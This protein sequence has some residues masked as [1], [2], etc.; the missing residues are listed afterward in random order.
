[1]TETER[2]YARLLEI[3]SFVTAT[4]GRY[5]AYLL[6]LLRFITAFTSLMV[7][8]SALPYMNRLKSVPLV[9]I[10]S[11]VCSLL[12]MAFTLLVAGAF[13]VLHL[14]ELSM[15]AAIVTFALLIVMY[16]L[17]FRFTPKDAGFVLLTPFCFFLRLPHVLPLLGGLLGSV[18]S[19]LALACGIV[20]YYFLGYI[21]TNAAFLSSQT[22]DDLLTSIKYCLDGLTGNKSMLVLIAAFALT[23][24]IVYALRRL[25]VDYAWPIAI[26]A[27]AIV[28]VV[29]L[30]IGTLFYDTDLNVPGLLLSSVFSVLI[31][32]VVQFFA[33]NMDYRRTENVQ[34][35]DDEYYYYVKAIPKASVPLRNPQVKRIH[36]P[37]E[38]TYEK[39]ERVPAYRSAGS[40]QA[41]SKQASPAS[42][43]RQ[44]SSAVRQ[45][46]PS[47]RQA[48]VPS[49]QTG[50]PARHVPAPT[51]PA[52]SASVPSSRA[53]SAS[54]TSVPPKPNLNARQGTG[55][56]NAADGNVRGAINGLRDL[57]RRDE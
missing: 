48:S 14:Y 51:K 42:P 19:F 31:A 49:R 52:A 2:L 35:E 10:V 21:R 17:Y 13:I 5:E 29:V 6:P 9:L 43:S 4:V 50:T 28:N 1:M 24:V 56:R 30:L 23:V 57:N 11:L 45:P 33:F 41:S 26:I 22:T 37:M 20:L 44:A 15:G 25:P 12:P 36:T 7:I 27:G 16:L 18:G 8:N 38:G 34:F 54:K 40:R 46:V 53:S 39:E 3:K 47:A 55:T 32:F